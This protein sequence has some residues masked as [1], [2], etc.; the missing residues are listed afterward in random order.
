MEPGEESASLSAPG[1]CQAAWWI[2]RDF[3]EMNDRR[4]TALS[5]IRWVVRGDRHGESVPKQLRPARVQLELARRSVRRRV[6]ARRVLL[7]AG[8]IVLVWIV[9]NPVV[10][11][12]REHWPHGTSEVLH[13]LWVLVTSPGFGAIGAVI[14]ALV[15][16]RAALRSQ[17][18]SASN[19][20]WWETFEWVMENRVEKVGFDEGVAEWFSYLKG[21]ASNPGESVIINV[22]TEEA[23]RRG[24]TEVRPP[25]AQGRPSRSEGAP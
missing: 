17:A 5:L 11:Y 16:F 19:D 3:A 14:A 24:R 25:Y 20:R 9:S 21:T 22:L 2:V 10:G 18:R 15:A 8:A 7:A 13:A 4:A 23:I 1:R 6:W 12:C